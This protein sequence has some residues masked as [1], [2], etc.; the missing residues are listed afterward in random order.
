MQKEHLVLSN[1][2]LERIGTSTKPFLEVRILDLSHNRLTTLQGIECFPN[3]QV[4]NLGHNLLGDMEVLTPLRSLPWLEAV[5]LAN[6]PL[7]WNFPEYPYTVK[8]VLCPGVQA[9]DG[10]EIERSGEVNVCLAVLGWTMVEFLKG[11]GRVAR[12]FQ[13]VGQMFDDRAGSYQLKDLDDA[14]EEFCYLRRRDEVAKEIKDKAKGL[15]RFWKRARQLFDSSRDQQLIFE[16]VEVIRN[17]TSNYLSLGKDSSQGFRRGQDETPPLIASKLLNSLGYHTDASRVSLFESFHRGSYEELKYFLPEEIIRLGFVSGT[18]KQGLPEYVFPFYMYNLEWAILVIKSVVDDFVEDFV[19]RFERI[20]VLYRSAQDSNYDQPFESSRSIRQNSRDATALFY[21]A[22]LDRNQAT[23]K[24][25]LPISQ[26]SR[27]SPVRF[28]LEPQRGQSSSLDTASLHYS[29]ENQTKQPTAGHLSVEVRSPQSPQYWNESPEFYTPL[30]NPEVENI[31]IPKL[32]DLKHL[33]PD[34]LAPKDPFY[35]HKM[36]PISFGDRPQ[37][38]STRRNL[39]S[40]DSRQ[41]LGDKEMF[42]DLT[43]YHSSRQSLGHGNQLKHIE[44]SVDLLILTKKILHRNLL[45]KGLNFISEIGLVENKPVDTSSH[46]SEY[47]VKENAATEWKKPASIGTNRVLFGDQDPEDPR[48][49]KDKSASV[50]H[51][52]SEG[53]PFKLFTD[54]KAAPRPEIPAERPSA[55]TQS[56]LLFYTQ[57]QGMIGVESDNLRTLHTQE[58]MDPAP[59]EILSS[60][61]KVKIYASLSEQSSNQILE[62]AVKKNHTR[63]V[64]E[65]SLQWT[66]NPVQEEAFFNQNNLLQAQSDHQLIRK[67]PSFHPAERVQPDKGENSNRDNTSQR[68]H[69]PSSRNSPDPH[70]K[71]H[72]VTR[73]KRDLLLSTLAPVLKRSN[74]HWKRLLSKLLGEML[75]QSRE[76]T[77]T[78]KSNHQFETYSDEHLSGH[79]PT[80]DSHSS[81]FVT[82][83]PVV[84]NKNVQNKPNAWKFARLQG[85][86]K[87]NGNTEISVSKS[88]QKGEIR[89][90]K[91]FKASLQQVQEFNQVFKAARQRTSRSNSKPKVVPKS[92]SPI[93][94]ER[95]ASTVRKTSKK[96]L[97]PCYSR[98][99]PFASRVIMPLDRATPTK[100][101]KKVSP[102]PKKKKPNEPQLLPKIQG[103]DS[104]L[105]PQSRY[106]V[107]LQILAS[108]STTPVNRSVTPS[109]TNK[110]VGASRLEHARL[111]R[112]L[113][114]GGQ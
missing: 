55:K 105:T 27:D 5:T 100:Q 54:E 15:R 25:L 88:G 67:Q 41:T 112:H 8:K 101:K 23:W 38:N 87:T 58:G 75:E 94:K 110:Q 21:E 18:R 57:S 47:V 34:R 17:F 13:K 49:N 74:K 81:K 83:S 50:K 107:A 37:T 76:L 16:L 99:S 11:V 82:F 31:S 56:S 24:K 103:F 90:G 60:P 78:V 44:A 9:I 109:Q 111:G 114:R 80:A 30:D 53:T 69:L 14:L 65:P 86:S 28:S 73:V 52:R 20:K 85:D 32:G 66:K 39:P 45:R 3:L 113:G 61:A 36:G 95:S 91:H 59:G 40:Q 84:L 68:A 42:V 22:T 108:R 71:K 51:D 70:D 2:G 77:N 62:L 26:S 98:K 93:P 48:S 7:C 33:R 64:S 43:K 63:R 72:S 12:G 92:V 6:N 96:Q 4:L 19:L 35:L 79:K 1:L 106:E 89:V 29:P 102:Q 104:P 46:P 97:M 10:V